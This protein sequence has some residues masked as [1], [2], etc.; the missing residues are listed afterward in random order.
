MRSPHSRSNGACSGAL[1]ANDS[2]THRLSLFPTLCSKNGKNFLTKKDIACE[3]DELTHVYTLIVKTD[4][5]YEVRPSSRR[6][7]G[8]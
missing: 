3:T 6:S 8:V 5:S 2:Q 4:N 1:A 7:L